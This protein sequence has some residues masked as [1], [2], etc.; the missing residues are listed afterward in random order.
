MQLDRAEPILRRWQNRSIQRSATLTQRG[1]GDALKW[2]AYMS[3]MRGSLAVNFSLEKS[4]IQQRLLSLSDK[5]WPG[6]IQ[7]I[8]R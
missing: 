8:R 6:K 4:W 2:S 3:S 1:D 7:I 5:R